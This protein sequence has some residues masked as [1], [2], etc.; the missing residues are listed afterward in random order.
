MKRFGTK[1]FQQTSLTLSQ[2]LKENMDTGDIVKIN[3]FSIICPDDLK[4]DF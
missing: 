2:M 4:S 1:G 3:N